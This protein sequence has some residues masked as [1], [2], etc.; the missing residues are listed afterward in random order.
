VKKIVFTGGGSAGHVTPNIALIREFRKKGWEIHYIGTKDGIEFDIMSKEDVIYHPIKAG[1]L[2]RYVDI[3]NFTD[4]FKIVA[5]LG[6]SVSLIRKIKPNI[7]FSKGGFVTVPVVMAGWMNRV[8][9]ITHESDMTPGLA[10]KLAI[11]FATKVCTAFPETVKHLPSGKGLY[12]GLPI[13]KELL[14]GDKAKG[15]K[16]TALSSSR[17]I[18]TIIG[19]SL[20]SRAINEKIRSILPRI[21]KDFQ[22]I[23]ICGKGNLDSSLKDF[24]GYRQYEYVGPELPHIF[25]CTDMI[26]SR[27][28]ATTLFEILALQK[29]SIIIPLPLSQSR[30]DQ[31]LNARSF[32]KQGYSK[33]VDE[34]KLTEDL[35]IKEIYDLHN[36]KAKYVNKI[37]EKNIINS[38]SLIIQTLEETAK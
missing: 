10:N 22:V 8:P 21:S 14:D 1:K 13:R 25:A 23:H 35:L 19:G 24:E 36:N 4:P 18:I 20:G 29:P 37:K 38:T 7:I 16:V 26:I 30:G 27:A 17:P 12:T 9:V 34:E 32:E 31:I 28:G 6:Q 3:K 33:S 11:P 5:G 2:R 15:L